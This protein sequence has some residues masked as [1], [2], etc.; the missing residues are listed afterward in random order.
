MASLASAVGLGGAAATTDTTT[1]EH[2]Q[3]QVG[4]KSLSG[5]SGHDTTEQTP[6]AGALSNGTHEQDPATSNS[7]LQFVGGSSTMNPAVSH[8]NGQ[9]SHEA[10]SKSVDEGALESKADPAHSDSGL[11]FI[12]KCTSAYKL[13]TS[14]Y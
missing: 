13:N 1:H 14:A 3:E 6:L 12:C 2:Q 4:E 5:S 10:I 9:Q 8:T 7:G 11:A